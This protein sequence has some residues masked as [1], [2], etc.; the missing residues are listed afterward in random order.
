MGLGEVGLGM[1]M[2][3]EVFGRVFGVKEWVLGMG[4]SSSTGCCSE[5]R[6]RLS[7]SPS[8]SPEPWIPCI[9]LDFPGKTSVFGRREKCSG[10]AGKS[11]ALGGGGEP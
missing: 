5:S 4:I 2:A 11:R 7:P 3:V 8:R 1:E 9:A 10:G 6:R